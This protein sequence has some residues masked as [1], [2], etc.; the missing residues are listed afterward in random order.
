MAVE[1]IQN[2]VAKKSGVEVVVELG[3]IT[4]FV[5]VPVMDAVGVGIGVTDVEGV[6]VHPTNQKSKINIASL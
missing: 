6:E 5:G 4:I 2:S 1:V 3:V